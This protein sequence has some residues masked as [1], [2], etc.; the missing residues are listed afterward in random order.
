MKIHRV[1]I[2]TKYDLKVHLIWV[3]TYRIKVM[4]GYVTIRKR[5][6]IGQIAMEHEISILSFYNKID[7]IKTYENTTC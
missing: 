1:G 6:I 2:H 3:P 5:D 7:Y 4:T